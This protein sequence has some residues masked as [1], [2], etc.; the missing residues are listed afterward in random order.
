MR[1]YRTVIVIVLMGVVPMV[2]AVFVMRFILPSDRPEPI[3]APPPVQQAAPAPP[4]V[5]EED[6]KEVMVLGAAQA[7]PV[8]TLLADEHLREVGIED[9]LVRRWHIETENLGYDEMPYGYVVREA[10]PAGGPVRW[11]S[12][13]GPRQRGFLAAVLKPGM[14][15][16]TVRLGAGTRHS[17]L[18]DPGDRVDVVLTAQSRERG[19]QNA[20][21][22]TILE[23]VRVVAVDRRI[24]SAAGSQ[25]GSGEVERAE[26]ATAT[27]EVLPSQTGLL[28]LGELEGE[29][30]LAVRALAATGATP[31]PI[32]VV[33]MRSLL[34]LPQESLQQ[35]TVRIV[36]GSAV[37][38]ATFAVGPKPASSPNIAMAKNSLVPTRELET[39]RTVGTG[40]TGADRLPEEWIDRRKPPAGKAEPA[41]E[42]DLSPAVDARKDSDEPVAPDAEGLRALP[43]ADVEP[44]TGS[45][46]VLHVAGGFGFPGGAPEPA[47]L[48]DTREGEAVTQESLRQNTVR[49]VRGSA[50]S[51][52]TFAAGAQPA[53]FSKT[54]T[55]EKGLEPARELET[56][57]TVG[58]D[59]TGLGGLTGERIDRRVPRASEVGSRPESEPDLSPATDIREGSDEPLTA[60]AEELHA[61]AAADADT[62]RGGELVQ[63]LAGGVGLAGG[64]PEP[65]LGADMQEQQSPPPMSS[66][67]KTI[68]VVRGNAVSVVTF[69][70][71]EQAAAFQEGIPEEHDL[72]E[73]PDA[74]S[75]DVLT[76]DWP[77][78]DGD[79]EERI[80]RLVTPAD[81]T[82]L[83]PPVETSLLSEAGW[84]DGG[85]ERASPDIEAAFSPS[86]E[87]PELA[88]EFVQP[89]SG[90]GDFPG[91]ADSEAVAEKVAGPHAASLMDDASMDSGLSAAPDHEPPP[92]LAAD[93]PR[94]DRALDERIELG[95]A[96]VG[97]PAPASPARI[98]ASSSS[99]PRER[100]AEQGMTARPASEP[101]DA[102][103]ADRPDHVVMPQQ[104]VSREAPT[105]EEAAS[106][107]AIQQASALALPSPPLQILSENGMAIAGGGAMLLGWAGAFAWLR[108]QDRPLRQRLQAVGAPLTGYSAAE[109]VAAEESIFRSTRPKSRL[110]WLWKRIERRY[111]LIDAPR[112][113]PRLVGFGVL[114]AAVVW[115]AM[116]VI[117]MSGWWLT[118]AAALAGLLGTWYALKQMQTRLEKQFAQRFPEIVDQ[119]VRLSIAGLPP[120]EALAKIA[121]DA[122]PP[123]KGVLEEVADALLAGLDADTALGMVAARVRLSE[124]TLFAAVIRLQRRAGGSISGAFS[125]LANTL[126]E[127]QT[128][129]LKARAATAQTRLTLLVLMLMPPL[130]LG[131]QT[132][133]MPESVDLLF[134][135]EDGQL[136]LQLGVGL[137]LAGLFLA[138]KIA[139]RGPK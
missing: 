62:G 70:P 66:Q 109:E 71:D 22:R 98:A 2:A 114:V 31:E 97:E 21:A 119:I 126:R 29:L 39:P 46:P 101:M 51:D 68:K 13:V 122:Q 65:A 115:V 137:I 12:L 94:L 77:G 99:L 23:D 116:W 35:K 52:A 14:R 134:S 54:V 80:D 72:A 27:L 90:G 112:A 43:A 89:L 40:R 38:D 57:R 113:F 16:I 82:E 7:L 63:R 73:R 130:V 18:V 61:F 127:R 107:P 50:V 30:S 78:S 96:P 34:A 123:V 24:A 6:P 105:A 56:L 59:R 76:A 100:R 26:I 138:R 136:L 41:A 33:D 47:L 69:V 118:P 15:A 60:D 87:D 67:H 19:E 110:T 129:E 74:H 79:A 120:L 106:A 124:F 95:T 28:A 11:P 3:Q 103:K 139:A 1:R 88:G 128:T 17:G 102:L 111:P 85:D 64:A 108:R 75:S 5:V 133:V 91:V 10:I 36:R 117:G 58:A 81:N 45:E 121:E 25:D 135:T 9:G 84:Q 32:D 48:A 8:G 92:T 37:S 132:Q 44:V 42:I 131:M 104:Q 55:A 53:S 4:P 93:R 125:N 86:A 83:V 49:I 20:L